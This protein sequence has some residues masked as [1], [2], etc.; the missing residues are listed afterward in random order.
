MVESTSFKDAPELILRAVSQ[1]SWAQDEAV[2][3]IKSKFTQERTEYSSES[4]SLESETFNE[5]LL[6]GYFEKSVINVSQM[7][8]VVQVAIQETQLLGS[9]MMTAR[10]NSDQLLRLCR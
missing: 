4:M 10:K 8:Q 5:L 3:A 7:T 9:I 1:L 6:L 2:K